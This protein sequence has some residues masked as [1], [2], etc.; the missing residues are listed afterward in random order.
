M[1]PFHVL[2]GL[3]AYASGVGLLL[4]L[5]SILL[6]R[7]KRQALEVGLLALLGTLLL[8]F[9]SNFAT[10]V[11]R[12]MDLAKVQWLLQLGDT[13]GFAALGLLPALLLHTH[14]LYYRRHFQTAG[15]EKLLFRG[16]LLACYAPLLLLPLALRQ[17]GRPGATDPLEELGR[18]APGFLALLALSYY[19]SSLLQ[20]RILKRSEN[21]IE[22][23]LFGRLLPL[24]LTIPVFNF[25]VFSWGGREMVHLGP[26]LK[27]MALASSVLPISVVAYYICRYRFLE[28]TVG[29]PLATALM[30]LGTLA[31]YLFGI[32]HLG[33]YLQRELS[34]PPQLVEGILLVGV[35]LLFAPLSRW[36]EVQTNRLFQS[37]LQRYRI[38]AEAVSRMPPAPVDVELLAKAIEEK[39]RTE[40]GA[41]YVNIRFGEAPTA[42]GEKS[43]FPLRTGSSVTG[44]LEIHFADSSPLV[45]QQ[46]AG[47]LLANEVGATLERCRLLQSKLAMERELAHKTYMEDL[48]RMA[49]TVAHNVKNPLSSM[50]TILQLLGEGSNLHEEQRREIAM[51]VGE[52][53]RLAR[54]VT[55]LLSFSRKGPVGTEAQPVLEKIN[56]GELID[57]V[58]SVFRGDLEVRELQVHR[59]FQAVDPVVR[60]SLNLLSEVFSNV[61]TNAVDAS[62]DRGT[63][64]VSIEEGP[65]GVLVAVEDDGSGVSAELKERIFEPFVT[66]KS[67]GTGLGLPI[68]R[69]HLALLGGG[70][71]VGKAKRLR[72]ARFD[73]VIPREARQ[74]CVFA[75]S[76]LG[77][78]ETS[79]KDGAGPAP[80]AQDA[81]GKSRHS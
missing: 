39:I 62:P 56:L 31:A 35:L 77:G 20:V 33:L 22:A 54:T 30:I 24:F 71:E 45:L 46:E 1:M 14:W 70:L 23:A 42:Q 3:V 76:H 47:R 72:G 6:K 66:S 34:A 37:E 9:S 81:E 28:L 65:E 80:S 44:S 64:L 17:L 27:V 41:E 57:S 19:A 55:D 16:A 36:L 25:F 59:D 53:D 40:L 7:R 4:F 10:L 79:G 58:I 8:W 5:L 21:R 78:A 2:L 11:L 50:K 38:T 32:R 49:S 12:Q 18:F 69:K 51:M 61:L 60:S 29:R 63:I 68:A 67:R 15:W 75:D 73:I 43:I 52:I 26:S 48:G 13:T 74:N